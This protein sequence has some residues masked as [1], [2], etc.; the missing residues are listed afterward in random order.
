MG[1]VDVISILA[2]IVTVFGVLWLI[3]V[4]ASGDPEREAEEAAREY[5]SEHGHWPDEA[6]PR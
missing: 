4:A 2:L 6:P 3:K 1:F 5:F